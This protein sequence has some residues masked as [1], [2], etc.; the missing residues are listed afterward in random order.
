MSIMFK[1]FSPKPFYDAAWKW[2]G[3][4]VGEG[5]MQNKSGARRRV[6]NSG[7]VSCADGAWDSG[8]IRD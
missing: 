8:R 1:P 2:A 5:N 4:V 3:G 7:Q 6:M